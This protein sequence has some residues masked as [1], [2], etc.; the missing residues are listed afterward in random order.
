MALS[1]LTKQPTKK[2]PNMNKQNNNLFLVA[3]EG[4]VAHIPERPMGSTCVI[5]DWDDCREA[6]TTQKAERFLRL[7]NK[8]KNLKEATELSGFSKWRN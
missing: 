6:G 5:V 2:E 8:G 3:V 4:G 1:C 7:L